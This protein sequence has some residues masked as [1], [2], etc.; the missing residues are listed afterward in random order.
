MTGV[1]RD[2]KRRLKKVLKRAERSADDA[3]DRLRR[4]KRTVLL[5]PPAGLRLGNLLYLWLNAHLR[6]TI[7]APVAVLESRDTAEWCRE[8]PALNR[9]SLARADLRFADRREWDPVWLYQRFGIDFTRSQLRAFI[10]ETFRNRILPD[11]TDRL[12]LNV[13]RGDFY[14]EFV[15][16]HGFDI[17]PYVEEALTRFDAVERILV[18]SDDAAWCRENLD[19]MLR[20]RTGLVEYAD[21][22][23]LQNLLALAGARRLI[24]ANS[25]FSYWGAYMADAV[26]DDAEIVMPRFHARMAHGTDAHQ[27]DPGWT[28][29]D[30]FY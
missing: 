15:A 21:P 10:D 28:I 5:A 25:T 13:R 3:V 26:H 24:G 7:D 16:K 20:A 22:D 30:G 18:V 19:R 8:F 12:V 4:G 27:L 14:T 2:V 23:P 17:V 11:R 1:A 6:T 9:L 29:L